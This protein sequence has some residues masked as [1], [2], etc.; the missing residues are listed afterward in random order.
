[1]M[2]MSAATAQTKKVL[3]V[4]S[5]AKEL[6]LKNGKTYT[7]TGVFLSEF[8]LAYKAIADAGYSIEI[9]T[10]QG[11]ASSIDNES[12]KAKYWKGQEVLIGEAKTFVT[13]NPNFLHP[14]TPEYALQHSNEYAGMVIPGGQ[15]LMVD[16]IHDKTILQII[17]KMAEDKKAVGLICHAPALLTSYTKADN[18]FKGYTVNCIT[19]FEEFYI[20][21]FVMKGKPYKRKIARSLKKLG[22]SYKKGGPGSSFAVKDRQL[23]TSQNPYSNNKFNALYL[24]ALEEYANKP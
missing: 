24:Q 12:Y 4:M 22:F 7:Q 2:T 18:P 13:T 3:F 15:G 21:R 23:V 10:P 19:G 17:S 11:I 6:P 1:M 16:L 8:Y 20:E 5:A 14:H 9:A